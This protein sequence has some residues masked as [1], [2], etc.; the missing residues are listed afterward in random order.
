MSR[1]NSKHSKPRPKVSQPEPQNARLRRRSS[2]TRSWSSL[3][4]PTNSSAV[5]PMNVSSPS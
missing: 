2:P 5:R 4:A 1:R 3:T